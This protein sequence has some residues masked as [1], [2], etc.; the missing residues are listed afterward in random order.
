[1]TEENCV[2]TAVRWRPAFENKDIIDKET[3]EHVNILVR[4]RKF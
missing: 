2:K 1:M 3:I 4:F